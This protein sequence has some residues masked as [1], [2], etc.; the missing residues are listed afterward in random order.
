MNQ[1]VE[2]SSSTISEIDINSEYYSKK[3]KFFLRLVQKKY[4]IK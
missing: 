4:F 1:F 3:K 2:T